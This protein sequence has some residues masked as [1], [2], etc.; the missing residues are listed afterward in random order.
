MATESDGHFIWIM[1]TR[2]RENISGII[3]IWRSRLKSCIDD[4]ALGKFK[5]YFN[6]L[7]YEKCKK[8]HQQ[9]FILRLMAHPNKVIHK[10]SNI[11]T[12]VNS[13]QSKLYTIRA[14]NGAKHLF[15]LIYFTYLNISSLYN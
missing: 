2:R 8:N 14:K 6:S 12:K 4:D 1:K 3:K 15:S 11:I 9:E 10:F 7:Y 5:S 13:K